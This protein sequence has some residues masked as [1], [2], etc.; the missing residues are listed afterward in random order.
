MNQFEKMR[1]LKR[2]RRIA[3]LMDARFGIPFTRFRIGLDGI[4]GLI[5]GFGDVLTAAVATYIVVKAREMGVSKE[6][7]A[8]MLI[9][10][11]ADFAIGF[12][13]MV[14]DV[15]DF[16]FKANN[17]NIEL[18]ERELERETIEVQ[19]VRED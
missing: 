16:F 14:G 2:L 5:P 4:L 17:R 15:A 6:T 7:Q 3:R 1:Q 18:L 9:N 8:R 12:I 13:P 10:V 11:A 19:A